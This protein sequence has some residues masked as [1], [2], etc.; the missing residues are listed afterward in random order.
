MRRLVLILLA[1]LLLLG[2]C[3]LGSEPVPGAA[4]EPDPETLE[5]KLLVATTA[6]PSTGNRYFT[7]QGDNDLEPIVVE[8]EQVA[9]WVV[10]APTND[11]TLW[12]VALDDGTL[13]GFLVQDHAAESVALN[14]SGLVQGAPPVL[15]V[16]ENGYLVMA[17][18]AGT[19]APLSNPLPFA[20]G[21]LSF[22]T[23]DGAVV[24][25]SATGNRRFDVDP[26]LDGR[27]T[28][29]DSDE[30]AVLSMPT[31]RYNHGVVG[32]EF[33]ASQLD[34]VSLGVQEV[35]WSVGFPQL[36][37]EGVSPLWADL[38]GD[39]VQEVVV[40]LSDD[41]SGARLAV[42]GPDGVVAESEPIGLGG[43]WRHQIAVA[44]FGPN[45]EVELVDIRTPHITGVA[46]FFTLAGDQLEM[47]ASFSGVTTHSIGSRNLDQGLA[48]DFNGDGQ[49]ELVASNAAR[50]VLVGVQRT[51]DGAEVVYE[52]ALPA[53][54]AS[55]FAGVTDGDRFSFAVGVFDGTL[56]IWP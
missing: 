40:T 7:G 30:L 28:V 48:A 14:L 2:A 44:P 50:D 34:V 17:A 27:L 23:T 4:P 33:E 39:G 35:I 53:R 52:V 15:L 26:L 5:G 12:V 11:G 43:R 9:R 16:S 13:T 24:V 54:I 19:G 18:P 8:L 29:S 36:V 22:V 38:D 56:L 25:S 3:G 31:D 51:G 1:G 55:N 49:V 32:D 6:G 42:L 45:G 41:V 37:I 47:A 21:G 20:D 46:E 10:G